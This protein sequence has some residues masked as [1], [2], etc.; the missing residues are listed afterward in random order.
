MDIVAL[1]IQEIPKTSN[2]KAHPRLRNGRLSRLGSRCMSVAMRQLSN[3][4]MF[5]KISSPIWVIH[6]LL[7]KNENTT[8]AWL[9]ICDQI[10]RSRCLPSRISLVNALGDSSP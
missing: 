6:H 2:T 7:K 9:T 5:L 8:L 10:E 4:G 3:V 1:A